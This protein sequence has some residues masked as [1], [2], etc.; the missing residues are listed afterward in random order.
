MGRG[1]QRIVEASVTL[2]HLLVGV[3]LLIGHTIYDS[4]VIKGRR[5]GVLLAGTEWLE[6]DRSDLRIIR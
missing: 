3:A 6:L 2:L 5:V 4:I 1:T